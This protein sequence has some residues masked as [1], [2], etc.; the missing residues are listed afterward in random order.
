MD[1]IGF[2]NCLALIALISIKKEGNSEMHNASSQKNMVVNTCGF[3]ISSRKLLKMEPI[4]GSWSVRAI[5]RK[6]R[7]ATS[8]IRMRKGEGRRA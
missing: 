1:E 3:Q 4:P 8:E 7:R 5:A 6:R 2:H